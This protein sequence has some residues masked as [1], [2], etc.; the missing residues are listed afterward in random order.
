[1]LCVC[2]LSLIIAYASWR[3][4]ELPFRNRAKIQRR[5]L[6]TFGLAGFAGLLVAGTALLATD[7]LRQ[8]F[9]AKLDGVTRVRFAAI[10][11]AIASNHDLPKFDNGDCKF[12]GSNADTAFMVRFDGCVKKYRKAYVVVGDSHA[13][14]LYGAFYQASRSPFIVG[15]VKGGC[16]P[17]R[18]SDPQCPYFHVLSLAQRRPTAIAHVFFTQK[19]SYFLDDHRYLP[20]QQ[21]Q[22]AASLNFL[23]SFASPDIVTWLGPQMEPDVELSNINPLLDK[24]PVPDKALMGLIGLVDKRLAEAA[25]HRG[26]YISKIDLVNFDIRQDF[27]KDG[28]FTYSDTNHWSSFGQLLFGQ[29]MFAKLRLRGFP[30]L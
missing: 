22:I 16:R 20:L 18:V 3:W 14:N 27:Y 29:R 23:A 21:D 24:L 12:W 4:V 6:V 19:G 26:N 1:M 10:D 28:K 13:M 15:I 9:L 7:G 30:D 11:E 2:G 17:D 25:L 5:Q 8:S